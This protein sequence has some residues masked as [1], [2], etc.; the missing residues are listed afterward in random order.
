M[1]D[2]FNVMLGNDR[3]KALL[4]QLI[5]RA[6]GGNSVQTVGYYGRVGGGGVD[7]QPGKGIASSGASGAAPFGDVNTTRPSQ[8]AAAFLNGLG[9]GGAARPGAPAPGTTGD[10]PGGVVSRFLPNPIGPGSNDNVAADTG[11]DF[12]WTDYTAPESA[13]AADTTAP[14]APTSETTPSAIAN[15]PR[16][17]EGAATYNGYDAP[18]GGTTQMDPGFG[19]TEPAPTLAPNEAYAMLNPTQQSETTPSAVA[20]APRTTQGATTYNGY[21]APLDGTTQMDPGFGI[22]PTTGTTAALAP[23][24][25]YALLNPLTTPSADGRTLAATTPPPPEPTPAPAPTLP[26]V[27][28]TPVSPTNS[29]TPI[30]DDSSFA[31]PAPSPAPAPTPAPASAPS[32]PQLTGEQAYLAA[33]PDVAAAVASGQFSSGYAHYQQYG[34]GEGRAWTGDAPT[35]APNTAYAMLNPTNPTPAPAPAP[36]STPTSGSSGLIPLG[37]GWYF[38]PATGTATGPHG[39]GMQ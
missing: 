3:R 5:Q 37:N 30:I 8:V 17:A 4:A 32:A 28:Q 33:N 31:Q 39:S 24:D 13:T 16:T 20:N 1:A 15:A 18:I 11:G 23:N 10:G 35:P 36:S 6:G 29:T 25:A 38:N 9:P 34:Q 2:N 27:S 7:V 12:R 26:T 22:T 21:D 14:E 19:I